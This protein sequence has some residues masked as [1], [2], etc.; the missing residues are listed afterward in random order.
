MHDPG[1]V[2]KVNEH[3][4][5]RIPVEEDAF[6]LARVVDENRK[7]LTQWLPWLDT[8]KSAADSKL[9]IQ[10]LH[11]GWETQQLFSG[12]I[13][14]KNEIVGAIGFHARTHRYMPMGYWISQDYAKQGICTAA[15]RALIGWAFSYYDDLNMIDLRAA[16]DNHA[17]RKV[18]EKLGFT[19]E[20]VLR[21]REWL[22]DRFVSH[23]VYT[24]TRQEFARDNN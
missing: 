24:I 16:T 14:K 8:S 9:Y 19:L 18:A 17:S 20:A 4:E 7:Y 5:I 10:N 13:Y 12:L 11:K 22:Y 1:P 6:Q 2:I 3:F 21:D 23:A 15:S